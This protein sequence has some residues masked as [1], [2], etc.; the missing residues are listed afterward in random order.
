MVIGCFGLNSWHHCAG[1]E[2][3]LG[4]TAV[5]FWI[6]STGRSFFP[7]SISPLREEQGARE[8]VAEEAR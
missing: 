2:P 6:K 7:L 5:Y 1:E 8:A 3:F 4:F